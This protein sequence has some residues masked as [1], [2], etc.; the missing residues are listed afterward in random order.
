M[1]I[2][3]VST[4]GLPALLSESVERQ[5]VPGT[6]EGAYGTRVE[7]PSRASAPMK[8]GVARVGRASNGQ[9]VRGNYQEPA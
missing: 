6:N 3:S 9:V 1:P 8:E 2:P 4:C 5:V 7:R